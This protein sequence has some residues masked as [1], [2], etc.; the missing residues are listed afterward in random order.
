MI[1]I[2]VGEDDQTDARQKI[3][4]TVERGCRRSVRHTDDV[5]DQHVYVH[6]F[7]R[8]SRNMRLENLNATPHTNKKTSKMY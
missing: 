6:V 2:D 3:W 1:S 8:Q 5:P 4:T 7:R